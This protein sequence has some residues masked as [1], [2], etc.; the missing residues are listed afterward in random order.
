VVAAEEMLRELKGFALLEGARGAEPCDVAAA[1]AAVSAL[2]V[3]AASED[4]VESV[5]VNPM[6]VFPGGAPAACLGL[7]ALIERR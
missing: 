3:F 4:E 1:A 7:D 5:E 2:S 6:R